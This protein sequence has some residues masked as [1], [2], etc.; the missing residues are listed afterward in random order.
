MSTELKYHHLDSK[1]LLGNT[2]VF[3]NRH[4]RTLPLNESFAEKIRNARKVKNTLVNN[5]SSNGLETMRIVKSLLANIL[6]TSEEIDIWTK[7]QPKIDIEKYQ[8]AY[9]NAPDEKYTKKMPIATIIHKLHQLNEV[10]EAVAKEN[11]LKIMM[12]RH[13]FDYNDSYS[14]KNFKRYLL[15]A[16]NIA[17]QLINEERDNLKEIWKGSSLHTLTEL[18]EQ[19][20]TS[21]IFKLIKLTTNPNATPKLR[22]ESL[23]KAIL[24]DNAIIAILK[25]ESANGT[26]DHVHDILDNFLWDEEKIG[27][28]QER[29]IVMTHDSNTEECLYWEVYNSKKHGIRG[30]KL[31][32]G[33]NW[34]QRYHDLPYHKVKVD[35]KNHSSIM[36][37]F[38]TS[39]TKEQVAALAKI[40]L[41]NGEAPDDVRGIRFV[42]DKPEDAI[43]LT[44]KLV[45]SFAKA[46]WNFNPHEKHQTL[47]L[48]GEFTIKLADGSDYHF[49]NPENSHNQFKSSDLGILQYDA[50]AQSTLNPNKKIQQFEIQ[51]Y[52]IKTLID[53]RRQKEKAHSEYVIRKKAAVRRIQTV[54]QYDEANSLITDNYWSMI[55]PDKYLQNAQE[56]QEDQI[57]EK[58]IK[59]KKKRRLQTLVDS[60]DNPISQKLIK[61]ARRK[62]KKDK[63]TRYIPL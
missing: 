18:Q 40:L 37:V 8:V 30:S 32:S 17:D 54:K 46:G 21:D 36:P 61:I 28:I 55:F 35:E 27:E 63:S 43:I 15:L 47:S 3:Q 20:K 41:K 49:S 1:A 38:M 33:K 25:I 58:T 48:T 60:P 10:S 16:A 57:D 23:R 22:E 50:S 52:T 5:K 24:I 42:V 11:L 2:G 12:T 9:K 7:D 19:A 26:M 39:R 62:I 14:Q 6:P 44:Q 59:S 34:V 29:G 13:N 45:D 4:E 53:S 51:I 56:R 31:P